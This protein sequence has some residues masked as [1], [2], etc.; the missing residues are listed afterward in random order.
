MP[1]CQPAQ[2]CVCAEATTPSSSSLKAIQH[3]SKASYP[4]DV[5]LAL[6]Y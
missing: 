6:A 3:S 1:G 2:P 4:A 5:E